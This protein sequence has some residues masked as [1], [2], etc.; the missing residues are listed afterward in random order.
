MKIGILGYGEVGQGIEKVYRDHSE[1]EIKIKDLERDDGIKGVEVLNVCIPFNEKFVEIV[2][3]E[4]KDNNPDLTII[5]STVVLGTTKKIKEL[6]EGVKIVHSPI[7]GVHPTLYEGIKTFV[8]YVGGDTDEEIS[9][10][11]DHL[12]K[13]GIK[14]KSFK[15]PMTTEMGKLL[16][17]TYYGLVIAWHGEMKKMCDEYSLD[18]DEVVT[19]FN[20]TYNRGYTKLGKTNVVRPVLY[21]PEEKIGGHCVISNTETLKEIFDSQALDL[22]LKYSNLNEN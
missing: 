21:P 14:V 7:R 12:K 6:V 11:E 4:I 22:I 10:A 17:T 3:K 8:K 19:D 9:L 2:A 20:K 15:N 16:D 1:I 18:F 5:H 13:L